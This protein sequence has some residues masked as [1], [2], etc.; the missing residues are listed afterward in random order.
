MRKV[1]YNIEGSVFTS[2]A[3]ALRFKEFT[4]DLEDR[5]VDMETIVEEV[6]DEKNLEKHR[7]KV[8]EVLT[9]GGVR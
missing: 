6:P 8:E 3:E 1:Y 2:Y 4:E 5:S 9:K 7:A